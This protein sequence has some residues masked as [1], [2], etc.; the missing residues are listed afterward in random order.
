MMMSIFSSFDVLSAEI[1]GQKVN[2]SWTPNSEKKQQGV[3]PLVS[4][5]KI[6]A[7]P[8]S[9]SSTGGLKNPG[10]AAPPSHQQQQKRPRFAPEFDG[11][12]CFETILPY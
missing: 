7:S 12:H 2:R 3:G 9:T 8:P 10:E 1:F 4:N 5:P 11:I 6:A